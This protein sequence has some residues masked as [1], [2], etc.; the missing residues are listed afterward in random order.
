MDAIDAFASEFKW[1]VSWTRPLAGTTAFVKFVNRDGRPINDVV[2]CQRLQ[3][4][5]EVMLVPGS[6]WFGGG[7]NFR[8]YVRIG[9]VQEPQTLLNGLQALRQFMRNDYEKLSV[10]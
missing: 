8:G 10:A 7:I 5:V 9:Y 6:G 1:A 4:Q 3:E 2:F